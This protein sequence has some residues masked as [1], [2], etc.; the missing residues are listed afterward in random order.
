MDCTWVAGGAQQVERGLQ[1]HRQAAPAAELSATESTRTVALHVR[2]LCE[3]A[4]MLLEND[5][6]A[7][8]E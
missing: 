7:L 2:Q 3:R 5:S 4:V 8:G 1:P 6:D